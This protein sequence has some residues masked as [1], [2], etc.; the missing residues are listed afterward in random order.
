M[1]AASFGKQ[2]VL[3]Y[4]NN[5]ISLMKGGIEQFKNSLGIAMNL[6]ALDILPYE[7]TELICYP[8]GYEVK[9]SLKILPCVRVATP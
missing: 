3:K 4:T 8:W 2:L 6:S 7:I 5:F 9:T 1:F